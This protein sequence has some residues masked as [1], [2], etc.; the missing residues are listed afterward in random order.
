MILVYTHITRDTQYTSPRS[1]FYLSRWRV[2][3]FSY[4]SYAWITKNAPLL[5]LLLFRTIFT[6]RFA[7]KSVYRFA[8]Y[9]YYVCIHVCT[10]NIQ[11]VRLLCPVYTQ[12]MKLRKLVPLRIY[13][14]ADISLIHTPTV[15]ELSTL[16]VLGKSAIVIMSVY[17]VTW[18]ACLVYTFFKTKVPTPSLMIIP[19]ASNHMTTSQAISTKQVLYARRFSSTTAHIRHSL[20]ASGFTTRHKKKYS[21]LYEL[22]NW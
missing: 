11:N 8:V 17:L 18:L 3:P 4:F 20:H 13:T 12:N 22:V 21:N 5:V 16:H 19:I 14:K 6:E 2:N 1:L 10:I 9:N 7:T 15:Y